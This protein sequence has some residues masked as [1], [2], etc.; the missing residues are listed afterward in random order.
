MRFVVGF[1]GRYKTDF[2]VNLKKISKIMVDWNI[3]NSL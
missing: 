1:T 2:N 3:S